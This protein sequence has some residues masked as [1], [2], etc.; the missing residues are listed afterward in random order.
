MGYAQTSE[1]SNTKLFQTKIVQDKNPNSR[2]ENKNKE[3]SE[4]FVVLEDGNNDSEEEQHG[5][6]EVV[7]EQIDY[8]K[9]FEDNDVEDVDNNQCKNIDDNDDVD[10]GEQ[11]PT[12]D[13]VEVENNDATSTEAEQSKGTVEINNL[14]INEI[15]DQILKQVRESISELLPS[16]RNQMSKEEKEEL[17]ALVA[18]KTV[19][20]MKAEKAAEQETKIVIDECWIEGDSMFQCRPCG[21]YSQCSDI[22]SKFH[23]FRKGKFG[24]VDKLKS[25]RS[26]KEKN[27][28]MRGIKKHSENDLHILCCLKEKEENQ[29]KIV[30]QQKNDDAGRV[31]VR[32]VIKNLKRGQSARDFEADNNIF[33]LES[34]YQKINI[35][36]KNNSE[37]AFYQI[38]DVVFEVVTE[39]VK[40]WFAVG[41]RGNINEISVTLDKVTVQRVSY[42]VLLTYYFFQGKIYIFLNCLMVMDEDEYDSPGTASAVVRNLIET[43]GV[44]R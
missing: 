32:N 17:A 4:L 36:T 38:R 40:K 10:N 25:D 31:T 28:I 9:Q 6:T 30:Q 27:V 13:A 39:D 19:E 44:T 37:A 3:G 7:P 12:T 5:Q 16:E 24:K 29:V 34:K 8:D 20:K 22:P 43:L 11:V 26:K 14:L 2:E 1:K 35:A 23:K 41:G 42:T 33:A 15:K 21:I 18:E